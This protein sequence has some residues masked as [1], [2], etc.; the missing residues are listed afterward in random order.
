MGALN[1]SRRA[2]PHR[3]GF[4][5]VELLTVIAIL[6]LL[7]GMLMPAVQSARE[8]AR[9]VSCANN[10][11]QLGLALHQYLTSNERLP[12]G[13]NYVSGPGAPSAAGSTNGANERTWIVELLPFI[14]MRNVSDRYDITRNCYDGSISTA[15]GTSNAGLLSSLFIPQQA[16]PSNPYAATKK[17]ID[18]GSI[19]QQM[20]NY[21]VCAGYTQLAGG[22]PDCFGLANCQSGYNDYWSYGKAF[23]YGMFSL[24]SSIQISAAD[25]RDGMSNTLMLLE[26]RG[27]LN[28]YRGL[29]TRFQGTSTTIRINSRWINSNSLYYSGGNVG[30]SAPLPPPGSP[31]P[32]L[33]MRTTN[34]GAASFHPGGVN[35]CMGDGAVQFLSDAIDFPTAYRQLGNRTD[36]VA[37]LP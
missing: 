24:C 20:L 27:E 14:D 8:T 29:F 25:V 30:L 7:V 9:R 19:S 31:W 28:N 26:T 16:C 15:T 21:G 5:L 2:T 12:F 36:G 17:L 3:I 13:D 33:D 11:K 4:T 1:A 34:N 18:G 6:G 23:T 32:L 37:I 22:S 10:V 35:V